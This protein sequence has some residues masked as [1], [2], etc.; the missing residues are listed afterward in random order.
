MWRLR[1]ERLSHTCLGINGSLR[2]KGIKASLCEHAKLAGEGK[3]RLPRG[4]PHD[5]RCGLRYVGAYLSK[6]L[7]QRKPSALQTLSH[8]T[9]LTDTPVGGRRGACFGISQIRVGFLSPSAEMWRHPKCLYPA[10]KNENGFCLLEKRAQM[11]VWRKC[12]QRE[13]PFK[14]LWKYRY[15]Y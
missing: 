7:L 13:G 15:H 5:H 6:V 12:P 2:P 10:H 9:F 3:S 11:H 4:P 1:A 8:F 14:S